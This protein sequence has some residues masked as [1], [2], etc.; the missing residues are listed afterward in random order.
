MDTKVIKYLT[1]TLTRFLYHAM[2]FFMKIAFPFLKLF[3]PIQIFLVNMFFLCLFLTLHFLH[4]LI[5]M[6]THAFMMSLLFHFLNLLLFLDPTVPSN[7]QNTSSQTNTHIPNTRSRRQTKAPAYLDQYHCY[8][9][10]KNSS[11]PAI[12]TILLLTLSHLFCLM[13]NLMPLTA[14]FFFQSQPLLLPKPFMRPFCLMSLR[15]L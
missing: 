3:P 2:W 4:S 15:V 10:N 9:L 5:L 11:F 1:Y 12:K 13:T 14:I 6:T 8:L 7:S